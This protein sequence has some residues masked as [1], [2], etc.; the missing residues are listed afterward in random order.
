MASKQL[1][2]GEGLTNDERTWLDTKLKSSRKYKARV[3]PADVADFFER[4][5]RTPLGTSLASF[6]K[7]DGQD[8]NTVD[9]W[10]RRGHTG[11]TS[12]L[13]EGLA[14]RLGE[15]RGASRKQRGAASA[16]SPAVP[17]SQTGQ[18]HGQ[19]S[20]SHPTAYPLAPQGQ[21]GVP[22]SGVMAS[23]AAARPTLAEPS[24]FG[25]DFRSM[26]VPHRASGYFPGHGG[27]QGQAS[28][29]R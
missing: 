6:A 8:P 27:I 19:S 25:K 26:P 13:K 14:E 4:F 15:Q 23:A 9:K 10:L 24:S 12:E 11:V 2:S 21:P 3:A 28:G 22:G 20:F 29:R 18:P 17:P 5:L 1:A 16:P 7:E